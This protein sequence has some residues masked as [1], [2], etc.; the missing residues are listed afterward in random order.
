MEEIKKNGRLGEFNTV[1]E[2]V[3]F[4]HMKIG[5][6]Y[7]FTN[8]QLTT[9]GKSKT[10]RVVTEFIDNHEL[11]CNIKNKYYFYTKDVYRPPLNKT[12][13]EKKIR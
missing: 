13:Q 8:M 12:K 6:L 11:Y 5:D 7:V 1:P 2:G 10:C 9:I 3:T 4:H